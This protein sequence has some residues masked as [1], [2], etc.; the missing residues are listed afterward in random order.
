MAETTEQA[1]AR[2]LKAAHAMQSGVAMKMNFDPAETEPKGLRTGINSAMV[3]FSA[4]VKLLTAKGILTEEEFMV[5]LADAM[6]AERALYEKMLSDH[7]NGKDIK[8]S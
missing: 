8:L 4:L 7:F 3:E 5:A 6:E 2:Y 1:H